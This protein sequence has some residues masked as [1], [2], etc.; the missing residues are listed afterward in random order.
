MDYLVT[1][2]PVK[3]NNWIVKAS[4]FDD[5]IL[6]FFLNVFTM[7]SYCRIFYDEEMA[8]TYIEKFVRVNK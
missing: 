7:Q 4:I 3:F 5:Q 6:I 8:H 2:D 1:L